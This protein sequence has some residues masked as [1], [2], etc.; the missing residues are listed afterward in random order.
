MDAGPFDACMLHIDQPYILQRA[1][2]DLMCSIPPPA[3]PL[4]APCGSGKTAAAV[5]PFL[6]QLVTQDFLLAPGLIAVLPTLQLALGGVAR[7]EAAMW[8][9]IRALTY[10]PAAWVDGDALNRE[11]C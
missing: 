3:T 5:A 11:I 1:V 7:H 10:V 4:W 6:H 8:N 2:F 9:G